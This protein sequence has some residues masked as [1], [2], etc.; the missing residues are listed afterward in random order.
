MVRC[1]HGNDKPAKSVPVLF[2]VLTLQGWLEEQFCSGDFVADAS[3]I[4]LRDSPRGMSQ[5]ANAASP[6]M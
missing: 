3:S 6:K 4:Y 2:S 1:M 5:Y